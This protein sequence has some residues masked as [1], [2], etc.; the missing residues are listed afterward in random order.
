MPSPHGVRIAPKI[1]AEMRTKAAAA[2]A[3]KA[4]KEN[5]GAR[6]VKEEVVEAKDEFDDM[7]TNKA[8]NRSLSEKLGYSPEKK[9]KTAKT[10]Q[11][12]KDTKKGSKKKKNPWESSDESG[13]ESG[14]DAAGDFSDVEAKSRDTVRRTAATTKYKDYMGGDSSES[15]DLSKMATRK[16]ATATTNRATYPMLPWAEMLTKKIKNLVVFLNLAKPKTNPLRISKKVPNDLTTTAVVTTILSPPRW[17]STMTALSRS[18]R[19]NQQPAKRPRP[20]LATTAMSSTTSLKKLTS[21]K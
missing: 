6:K 2:A 19:R 13:S 20:C 1:N 11:V 9:T 16:T 14:S 5:K 17:T 10:G 12:A 21:L 15:D 4:R 8:A 3:A 18:L 7:V